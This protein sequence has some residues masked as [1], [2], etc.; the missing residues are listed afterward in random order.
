MTTVRSSLTHAL[1]RSSSAGSTPTRLAVTVGP[2]SADPLQ[3]RADQLLA[4]LT[5]AAIPVDAHLDPGGDVTP[6]GLAVD[7][8]SPGDRPFAVTIQP[9][10]QHLDLDHRC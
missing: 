1:M 10:P 8:D 5:L 7:A 2:A 9:A 6:R 3:H 4:G